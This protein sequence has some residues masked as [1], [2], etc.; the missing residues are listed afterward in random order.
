MTLLPLFRWLDHTALSAVMKDSKW[1]FAVI[2]MVHLLGLAMLGGVVLI[3]NLRLLGLVLRTR[4]ADRIARDLAPFLKG[5]LAVM[6]VSG[7]PLVAEES[8]KCYYSPAFRLKMVF[9]ALAL[10][11]YY[12]VNRRATRT[13]FVSGWVPRVVAGVSLALWLSVGVAGRAIGFL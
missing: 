13:A 5:S 2:E 9:L 12:V 6:V 3:V 7:I 1:A 8:M 4:P 11:F 10:A